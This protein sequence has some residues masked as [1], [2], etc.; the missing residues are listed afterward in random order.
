VTNQSD[1]PRVVYVERTRAPSWE[2]DEAGPRPEEVQR[3][4]WRFRLEIE[5]KSRAELP[6]TERLAM[7][8]RYLLTSLSE[9]RLR[10]IENRGLLDA[11]SRAG[12][13]RVVALQARI[14][15]LEQEAAAGEREAAEIAADQGRLRENVKA[16]GD[17]REARELVA[18]WLG[19]ADAQEA[20]G[21]R[22]C[23]RP[24]GGPRPTAG[25][26]G[27]RWTQSCAASRASG[28]RECVLPLLAEN[29]GRTIEL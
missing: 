2:L 12:L 18:R 29:A 3:N 7:M 23:A 22:R 16:V 15:G 8:D 26:C 11:A 5:P 24:A 27:R 9:P 1:R 4:A 14:V 10:E 25:R 6:V 19:R 20:P 13:E 17:R 28:S 21:S